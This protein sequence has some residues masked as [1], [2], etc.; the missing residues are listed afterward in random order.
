[1]HSCYM[2]SPGGP[3]SGGTTYS[4][5]GLEFCVCTLRMLVAG[6]IIT[7]RTCARGKAIGLSSSLSARKSPDLAF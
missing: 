3:L 6:F 4:M 5:T 1:M 2:D 7:L